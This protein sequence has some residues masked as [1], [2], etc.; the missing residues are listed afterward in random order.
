MY[1]YCSKTSHMV[2]YSAST[3]IPMCVLLYSNFIVKEIQDFPQVISVK[4]ILLDS[5]RIWN[6]CAVHAW[7]HKITCGSLK[8]FSTSKPCAG[9]QA[10]PF[11]LQRNICWNQF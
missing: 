8:V 7:K 5:L 10:S 4:Y 11:L 1:R 2:I 9:V 3:K 6:I